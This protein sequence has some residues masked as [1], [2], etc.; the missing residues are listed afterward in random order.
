MNITLF[1]TASILLLFLD[2]LHLYFFKNYYNDLVIKVQGDKTPLNIPAILLSYFLIITGLYY[3]ILTGSKS[4]ID[5][6]ILGIIIYGVFETTN[7]AIFKNWTW[8]SVITDTLWGGILFTITT[9][10]LL[11]TN[12]YFKYL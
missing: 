12:S 10:I 1:I 5:A 8:E 11:F 7:L 9:Y 4:L 6:F 3:F 2:T